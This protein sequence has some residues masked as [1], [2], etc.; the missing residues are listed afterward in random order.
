MEL[1]FTKNPLKIEVNLSQFRAK[2]EVECVEL[3]SDSVGNQWGIYLELVWNWLANPMFS[4]WTVWG[5][6]RGCWGRSGESIRD[7]YDC[8]GKQFIFVVA[9]GECIGNLSGILTN[10]WETVGIH[11]DPWRICGDFWLRIHSLGE[12]QIQTEHIHTHAISLTKPR[13]PFHVLTGLFFTFF[14]SLFSSFLSRVW[15][16]LFAPFLVRLGSIVAPIFC[17]FFSPKLHRFF[18]SISGS[19]FGGC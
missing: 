7:Y 3:Y 10:Y 4:F 11:R 1:K 12:V 6:H 2:T 13:F 5:M 9:A 18:L 19:L 16:F 8:F 17:A 14:W 15:S